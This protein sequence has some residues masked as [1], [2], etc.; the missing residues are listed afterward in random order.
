MGTYRLVTY[1]N[2]GTPQTGIVIDEMI[3]GLEAELAAKG[4]TFRAHAMYAL[5]QSWEVAAPILNEIADEP[6]TGGTP[7]VSANLAAPMPHPGAIYCAGAN[8]YDHAK[9]MS[10]K[11]LDKTGIEPLFF[12]KSMGCIVDPGAPIRISDDY[13]Q[14]YDWEVE[15]ALIIGKTARK[16][17][18][19]NALDHV[20]GYTIMNDLS[21][22]DRGN[23]DDWPFGMDWVRHKSFMDSAPMGPWITP[24]SDIAD[25]QKL[26]LTTEISG[27]VKQ[28]SNSDQ[29]VF[30]CAEQIHFLSEQLTLK[31]GDIIATGTCAG[32][33][34]FAGTFLKP[35][36]TIK[37]TVEGLGVLENTVVAE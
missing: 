20:M 18:V 17:S 37:M 9:E 10:G 7:L 23:R 14:K 34:V 11:D 21:A 6:T 12:I 8:Y 2:D 29:M 35:G 1:E 19:D 3:H 24:A 16:V 15:I 26:A 22:R 36:D 4:Q 32:V 27:E 33:G 5:V 25:P 28:N 31:P 30:S 13:S